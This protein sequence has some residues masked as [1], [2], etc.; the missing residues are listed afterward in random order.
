MCCI[1][2][3]PS[4]AAGRCDFMNRDGVVIG[5]RHAGTLMKRMAIEAIYRRLNTSKLT[6]DHK[7]YP[8]LLRM[9]KVERLNQIW[10]INN[11]YMPM[12]RGF[13]YLCAVVDWFTRRALSHCV[14]ST[15]ETD[16]CVEPLEVAIGKYS[17]TEVFKTDQGSRFTSVNFTRVS[18]EN[19][20]AINMERKISWRDDMFVEQLCKSV[21]YLEVY[22]RA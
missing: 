21:N 4:R 5:R 13:A 12:V 20:I 2:S 8:Y 9:L 15:R 19:K 14:S 10:A 18:I 17:K 1:W 3:T 7:I 11:T 22:L 16:F 6:P